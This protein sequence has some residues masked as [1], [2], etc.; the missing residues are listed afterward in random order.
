MDSVL[1]HLCSKISLSD[2]E[3]CG[4]SVADG[5][6]ASVR[7][8][9]G[10][11]LIGRIGLEKPINREA[12]K[13]VLSGLWQLAGWVVFK[14]VQDNTWLFEFME[15][16]D[17]VRVMEGRTWSFDKQILVLKEFDGNCPPSKME[18]TKSPFWIQVHDLPLLC[19][20]QRVGKKIGDP[21]G[22]LED[23]D[24]AGD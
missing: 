10:R 23:I 22:M 13:S 18:F 11:C 9:G 15:G 20:N 7:E 3:K 21:L 2:G 6:I 1:E 8:I 14:E 17:K 19:M 16:V 24:V 5:E 4:I 12:F